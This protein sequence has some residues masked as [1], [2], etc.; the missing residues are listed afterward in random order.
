MSW[1]QWDAAGAQRSDNGRARRVRWVEQTESSRAWQPAHQGSM[2]MC[3]GSWG[4]RSFTMPLFTRH[5][6]F[7]DL[8]WRGGGQAAPLC[9]GSHSCAPHPSSSALAQALYQKSTHVN[10]Q[11]GTEGSAGTQARK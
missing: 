3:S 7:L 10:T 9:A 11:A 6:S 4:S 5:S 2:G 8:A 1:E